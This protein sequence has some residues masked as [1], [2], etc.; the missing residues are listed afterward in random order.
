MLTNNR[1]IN[2]DI[3]FVINNN[4][5]ILPDK[6][7]KLNILI[8]GA[9]GLLPSYL[10]YFFA[11][12][13]NLGYQINLYLIIRNNVNRIELLNNNDS[14]KIIGKNVA[15]KIETDIKFDY[16]VHAASDATP[17]KYLANKLETINTNVLGLYN[18]FSLD[19][20]NLKS[21]LYFST[22]ELYGTPEAS[23]IPTK[24]SYI[25]KF[26]HL[27]ER[28]CYVETKKFCETLCINMFYEK[29]LPVK[30]IRPFHTFGPGIDF[31][32]GRIFSEIIKCMYKKED[33]IINSDGK[34]TRSFC[35]LGDA[36]DMFI[37]VLFSDKNGEVFNVGNPNNEISIGDLAKTMCKVINSSIDYKIL[38]KESDSTPLKSCP[39]ILKG[40]VQ[41]GFDPRHNI[42]NAFGRTLESLLINN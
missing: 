24:E 2:E 10:V 29:N 27:Q 7:E 14:Y 1:I 42:E 39:D 25:S 9:N 26:D 34:A 35:Y 5:K 36:L 8:T 6:N 31:N 4:K 33:I 20:S 23:D 19:L 11:E 40:I 17:K 18:I 37:K 15:E 3:E 32:D 38:G 12:L 22:A 13:K 21:F 16:I 30:M 28:S 41:L